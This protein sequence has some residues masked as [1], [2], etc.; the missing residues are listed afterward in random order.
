MP[1]A[2]G[3]RMRRTWESSRI[4]GPVRRSLMKPMPVSRSS[5]SRLVTYVPSPTRGSSTPTSVNARTAS[6]REL[7]ESPSRSASSCS[8]GS[9]EPA[10]NS[11][12]MMSCLIFSIAWS[13]SATMCLLRRK[14]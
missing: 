6:R 9:R 5:G 4:V 13:V 1:V 2:T 8:F 3:S 11:P 10:A 14:R 12:S 7:R